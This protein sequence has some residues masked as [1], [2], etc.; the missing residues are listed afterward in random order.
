MVTEFK[1]HPT[2]F[3]RTSL[4]LKASKLKE[5]RH[6]Y[7]T[8]VL[9]SRLDTMPEREKTKILDIGRFRSSK[10]VSRYLNS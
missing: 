6:K 8:T 3:E 1:F 4:D 10:V 7:Y 9:P 5:V 2:E